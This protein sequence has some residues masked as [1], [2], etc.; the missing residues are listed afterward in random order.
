[1]LLETQPAALE[2]ALE[3]RDFDR[4]RTGGRVEEPVEVEPAPLPCHL[5]GIA[6]V[7]SELLIQ[8]G[9][10]AGN[11]RAESHHD[12]GVGKGLR[13]EAVISIPRNGDALVDELCP[14]K[15]GGGKEKQR[16][17]GHDQDAT[18]ALLI[19]RLDAFAWVVGGQR[20]GKIL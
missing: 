7:L 13:F 19:L 12:P 20:H 10:E 3:H 17:Q 1:M 5:D 2:V 18:R 16:P 8:Q 6:A 15:D 9:G 11:L 4:V 14:G